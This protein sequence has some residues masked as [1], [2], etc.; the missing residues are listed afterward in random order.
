MSPPRRGPRRIRAGAQGYRV[1][2]TI[3]RRKR[4]LAMCAPAVDDGVG[5]EDRVSVTGDHLSFDGDYGVRP[6]STTGR[7]R[8]IQRCT[9]LPLLCVPYLVPE[10]FTYLS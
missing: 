1:C 7:W 6:T 9:A 4:R 5:C 8:A 3:Y 10:L 2:N